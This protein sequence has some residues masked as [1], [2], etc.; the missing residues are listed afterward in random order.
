LIEKLLP[1]QGQISIKHAKAILGP[2][3]R[4]C[5]GYENIESSIYKCGLPFIL[6]EDGHAYAVLRSH[7]VNSRAINR[8]SIDELLNFWICS[9][10]I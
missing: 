4:I 10:P 1:I 6:I 5:E 9:N 8:T 7:A 3:V 2:Y